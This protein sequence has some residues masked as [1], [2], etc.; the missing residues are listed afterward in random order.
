MGFL[1]ITIYI[2]KNLIYNFYFQTFKNPLNSTKTLIISITQL[3][4]KKSTTKGTF[5]TL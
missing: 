1:Y 2:Y 5:G 3:K 4:L